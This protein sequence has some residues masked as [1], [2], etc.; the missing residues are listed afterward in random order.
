MCSWLPEALK[1]AD[2]K[3]NCILNH[4]SFQ[5]PQY[6][7]QRLPLK[8]KAQHALLILGG[9]AMDEAGFCY[10]RFMLSSKKYFVYTCTY[11][12]QTCKP[13]HVLSYIDLVIHTVLIFIMYD[14]HVEIYNVCRPSLL[15]FDV[16]K[17]A[18]N[19]T[20][21]LKLHFMLRLLQCRRGGLWRQ[22]PMDNID[23][24]IASSASWELYCW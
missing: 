6:G 2:T 4:F 10:Y 9:K 11:C 14:R 15:P 5:Q 22:H 21:L 23:L 12:A 19:Q 8:G 7:Q 13:M 24:L 16:K 17:N 1:P 18:F 3:D 20:A